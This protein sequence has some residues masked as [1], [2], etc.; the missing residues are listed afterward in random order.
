VRQAWRNL[1]ST[2]HSYCGTPDVAFPC[3]E[4]GNGGLGQGGR[5]GYITVDTGD[6]GRYSI[7]VGGAG[8]GYYGGGTAEA[9]VFCSAYLSG[10]AGGSSYL[11]PKVKGSTLVEG[12][13]EGAGY[14]S[15]AW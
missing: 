14:V 11:P 5:S 9:P 4:P 12:A 1:G 15:V 10:G 7:A 6:P 3:T 2:Q 8:G 13:N